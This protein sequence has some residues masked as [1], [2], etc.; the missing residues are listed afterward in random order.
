MRSLSW[1]QERVSIHVPLA[2][3]DAV[4]RPGS[5][6]SRVSIHVP[7]AEHDFPQIFQRLFLVVSIHVPLAEHDNLNRRI[8]YERERFNS[9]APRGARPY[10]PGMYPASIL[11]SIHVPL[12]E[13]DFSVQCTGNIIIVFQFTCPSRST[14]ALAVLLCGR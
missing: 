13:H 1:P 8:R 4:S 11:V 14:T 9:R 5:L 2:E 3:H 7:L 10:P 12:A 6:R